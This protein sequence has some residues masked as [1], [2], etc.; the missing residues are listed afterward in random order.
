[1]KKRKMLL[2]LMLASVMSLSVIGCTSDDD[3]DDKD[4]DSSSGSSKSVYVDTEMTVQELEDEARVLYSNVNTAYIKLETAG[5]A[6]ADGVITLSFDS[7][8]TSDEYIKTI[9]DVTDTN[10]FSGECEIHLKNGNVAYVVYTPKNSENSAVYPKEEAI[11]DGYRSKSSKS[12][13][14]ESS[15]EDKPLTDMER[16]EIQNRNTIN[17]RNIADKFVEDNPNEVLEEKQYWSDDGS[18]L[19][20]YI[21]AHIES[22]FVWTLRMEKGYNSSNK[23]KVC[24]VQVVYAAESFDSHYVGEENGGA[25]AVFEGTIRD[26]IIEPL[27]GVYAHNK[28][29]NKDGKLK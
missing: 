15:E 3:D 20:E 13:N 14:E 6:P 21:N 19:S 2:T 27:K 8:D 24:V 16:V 12:K 22:D 1:M 25:E 23:D 17:V 28:H 11:A 10:R 18:K 7:P 9:L 26:I 5:N 4:D 29:I